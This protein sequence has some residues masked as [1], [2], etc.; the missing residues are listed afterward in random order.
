M[1]TKSIKAINLTLAESRIIYLSTQKM[2]DQLEKEMLKRQ[3][4]ENFQRDEEI[5]KLRTMHELSNKL[6]K[7]L[8]EFL[9]DD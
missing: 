4:H 9:L 5:D 2:A 7:F 8:N 6:K 3:N 1:D